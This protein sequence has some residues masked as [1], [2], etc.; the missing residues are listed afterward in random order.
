MFLARTN[1]YPTH[2]ILRITT[3]TKASTHAC[4]ITKG[5]QWKSGV[6][7]PFHCI[8]WEDETRTLPWSSIAYHISCLKSEFS[9][10]V[11]LPW[12]RNLLEQKIPQTPPPPST[13]TPWKAGIMYPMHSY[14]PMA[15]IS[16]SLILS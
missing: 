3:P 14:F 9:R 5:A 10:N 12:N 7:R 15:S 4:F 11:I 13:K 8:L 1:M 6:S 2:H 16:L